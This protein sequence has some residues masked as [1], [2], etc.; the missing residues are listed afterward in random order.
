MY[1]GFFG[2]TSIEKGL[3]TTF[4]T[5]KPAVPLACSI[6]PCADT[7]FFLRMALFS[8]TLS[9]SKAEPSIWTSEQIERERPRMV[10]WIIGTQV[11]KS[12]PRRLTILKTG[13]CIGSEDMILGESKKWVT[14][15][16]LGLGEQGKNIREQKYT[17]QIETPGQPSR[18][19]V[20]TKI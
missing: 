17:D 16:V 19:K 6:A 7:V 4:L 13:V 14:N 8:V 10:G 12:L 15:R 9:K 20:D 1:S 3:N 5:P 2:R 11:N 18:A